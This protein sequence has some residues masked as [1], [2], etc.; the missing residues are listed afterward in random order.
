MK[1]ALVGHG[2]MGRAIDEAAGA[3]GHRRVAVVDRAGSLSRARLAGADVAFE[4]TEPRSA[5]AH[6]VAL[7]GRGISVV[8]GTTGWDAKSAAIERAAKRGRAAAIVAPNFSV[9]V[10]IFYALVREA[11]KRSLAAGYDPWIAEWHHKAK[12]DA[13]SG[14]ARRL[15]ALV[16]SK[17]LPVAAVR[18]G[19]EPGRHAVGF[20][21]A[22]DTIVLTHQARGREAFAAGAVLAAEWLKGKKGIHE[23]DEVL[24]DLMKGRGGKR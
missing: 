13:P 19:H 20:D 2:K 14:T 5:E 4:F 18:A 21:G 12:R 16:G 23:F 3:R 6:V 11:A 24:A 10:N 15:A 17:D 22:H 1:Y 9:G 7:L 8:C